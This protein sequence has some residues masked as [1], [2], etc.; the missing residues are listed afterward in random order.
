MMTT[1]LTGARLSAADLGRIGMSGLR[2]RPLRVLL[3][4]AGIAIGIAAMV[5]VFGVSF[6]SRADLTAQLE[7]L[8]TN[9]LRVSAGSTLFGGDAKLPKESVAMVRRIE[10][11]TAV[12]A[13]G[14]VDTT[15]R[16]TDQVPATNTGGLAVRAARTDLLD[17]VG[18]RLASGRWLDAATS[19]YP[20]VVLVSVAAE[21]LGVSVGDQVWL[22][23]RWFTVLGVLAPVELAPELDRTALVG[24]QAAEKLLGFDGHPSTIYERSTDAAVAEV[25]GL[26]PATV[27][28]EN[29]QE[30]E[31]SRPSDAL[32]A[33]AATDTAFMGLLL[34]LGA[35]A[36]L[37]G[38]VGVANTMV[39]AVMERRSEI[40]LRRAL[41]AT[42]RQVGSQFLVE[43]LLLSALGGLAGVAIGAAVTVGYSALRGWPPVMPLTALASAL[44][45]TILIGMI[46]GL[47]PA[48][49]AARLAPTAALSTP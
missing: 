15:V 36:L 46:A 49:R 48:V 30:V 43:S 10:S 35:V 26:L 33:K 19:R 22:G 31:V 5:A 13:T 39:I 25:R 42:R 41:G 6:S 9:L 3:S 17:A 28:P 11:V 23:E 8:G 47:Y 29:P 27:N 16:R 38:G 4:A 32:A 45:A 37:V 24:W 40:G 2:L 34:G 7:R 44:A 21:R 12:S 20:T 18:A 1:T 14:T